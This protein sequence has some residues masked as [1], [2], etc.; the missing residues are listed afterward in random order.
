MR[1]QTHASVPTTLELEAL[2]VA[3][4]EAWARAC[5]HD[6]RTQQRSV[7]G[8]WPGTLTEARACVLAAVAARG[9]SASVSI[10]Q[11]R[12][13]SRTAYGVARTTWRAV[14]ERDDEPMTDDTDDG[15]ETQWALDCT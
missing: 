6:L 3:A 15:D 4:G 1:R 11:L 9:A 12:A 5:A 14:C 8:G 10:D 7:A 13:L 2:A